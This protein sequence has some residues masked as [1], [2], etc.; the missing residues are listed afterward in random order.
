MFQGVQQV[1]THDVYRCDMQHVGFTLTQVIVFED[2]LCLIF[3]EFLALT[4]KLKTNFVM[5]L[6]KILT[7]TVQVSPLMN[8]SG[9]HI[10]KEILKKAKDDSFC[11]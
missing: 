4:Q 7:C 10:N 3:E 2:N 11:S 9:C 8:I 1:I 5:T 6:D